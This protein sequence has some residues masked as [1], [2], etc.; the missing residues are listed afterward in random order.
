MLESKKSIQTI[1]SANW[2]TQSSSLED[3]SYF[4]SIISKKTGIPVAVQGR[5]NSISCLSGQ[6]P[7]SLAK[8]CKNT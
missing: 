1:K 5:K 6:A 2:Y 3:V 4:E 8:H 7:R